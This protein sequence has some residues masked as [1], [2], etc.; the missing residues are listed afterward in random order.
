MSAEIFAVNAVYI[1]LHSES[2]GMQKK[3]L[4]LII[5]CIAAICAAGCTTPAPTVPNNTTVSSVSVTIHPDITHYTIL[6]SSAPGIGLSAQVNGTLPAD[7]LKYIWKTDY[8]QLLSWNA[9]DYTVG[10]L[11]N[12]STSRNLTKVYWTYN[13]ENKAGSRPPVHVTF[14]IIDPATGA[15]LGHAKQLIGWDTRND[16]AVIG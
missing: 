10:E 14:D 5:V 15:T 16:T 1:I 4:P 12:I 7:S 13:N 3:H 11:G 6:M 9:P 2:E 8:G